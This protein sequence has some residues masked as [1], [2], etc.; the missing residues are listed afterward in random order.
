MSNPPS[1]PGIIHHCVDCGMLSPRTPSPAPGSVSQSATWRLNRKP[2]RDGRLVSEWRC[3]TCW[4]QR[5]QALQSAQN[6]LARGGRIQ[7]SGGECVRRYCPLIGMDRP[8]IGSTSC[9]DHTCHEAETERAEDQ[10]GDA[11]HAAWVDQATQAIAQKNSQ[12]GHRA[13]R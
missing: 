1:S 3:P 10:R 11:L 13:Q 8:R 2:T 4:G 7:F 6:T 9:S 12:R 5:S